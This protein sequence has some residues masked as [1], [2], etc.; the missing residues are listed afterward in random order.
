MSRSQAKYGDVQSIYDDDHST[1]LLELFLDRTM[2]YS[3]AYFER[4]DMTLEEAQIAK[5]DLSLRKCDLHP[6]QTLLEIGCGYGACAQRAAEEYGVNV[7]AVTPSERQARHTA[8]RVKHLRPGA[9]RVEVHQQGWEEC[10]TPVDRIIS[11]GALEHIGYHNFPPFF[12]RC[13]ELLRPG[14]NFLLHCIV[15][16]GLAN[17]QKR[18]ITVTYDDVEFAKFIAKVIFPGGRLSDPDVICQFARWAGFEALHT[19]ALGLHYARTLDLWAENLRRNREA[20]IALK[21]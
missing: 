18:N 4:D 10:R 12:A 11:I 2:I 3:C 7:I 16:Y 21:G 15:R 17:L 6:G 5:L 20:A 14:G 13:F 9:G 8:E 19:E 1:D